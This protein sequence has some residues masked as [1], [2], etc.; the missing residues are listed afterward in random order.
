MFDEMVGER[1]IFDIFVK[2]AAIASIAISIYANKFDRDNF[3]KLHLNNVSECI[4]FAY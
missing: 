2:Y 1:A 3:V 4:A